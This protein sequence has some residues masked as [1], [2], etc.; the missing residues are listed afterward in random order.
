MTVLLAGALLL[1][2]VQCDLDVEAC[3]KT[4]LVNGPFFWI[5]IVSY[6]LLMICVVSFV[7]DGYRRFFTSK[8]ASIA[9]K[10]EYFTAAIIVTFIFTALMATN[11]DLFYKK[12]KASGGSQTY[13]VVYTPLNIVTSAILCIITVML[14]LLLNQLTVKQE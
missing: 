4:V 6:F 1:N 10:N 2:W 3:H 8:I 7:V 12:W 13:L 9:V 11:V 5:T 14:L